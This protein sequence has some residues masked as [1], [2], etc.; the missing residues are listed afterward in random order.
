MPSRLLCLHQ[1][2]FSIWNSYTIIYILVFAFSFIKW[3]VILFL[4]LLIGVSVCL[5]PM[6]T[7]LN[8]DHFLILALF[9]SSKKNG[10]LFFL[11]LC[12]VLSSFLHIFNIYFNDL[13]LHF[14]CNVI[15]HWERPFNQGNANASTIAYFCFIFIIRLY[16]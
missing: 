16:M 9:F 7:W 6:E 10:R 4:N 11:L 12:S 1:V 3:R 2:F 15:H 8:K 5:F 14:L 13:L